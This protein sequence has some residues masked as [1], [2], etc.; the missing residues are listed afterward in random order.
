MRDTCKNNL[1][2]LVGELRVASEQRSIGDVFHQNNDTAKLLLIKTL[3][4]INAIWLKFRR[5]IGLSLILVTL[6]YSVNMKSY[7]SNLSQT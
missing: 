5:E 2:T 6:Y 4:L 3:L 1:D 7:T